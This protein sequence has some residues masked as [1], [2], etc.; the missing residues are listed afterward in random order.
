[1]PDRRSFLAAGSTSLALA[2]L[3]LPP[4]P[5]PQPASSSAARRP[6]P[7]RR[8]WRWRARSAAAPAVPAEPLPAAVLDKIGYEQLG[9]IKFSTDYALWATGRRPSRPPSSTSA[10]SSSAAC[11]S[12]SSKAGRRARDPLRRRPISTCRPTAR[13]TSCRRARAS[14]AS[15]SRRAA[16]RRQL[17][18]RKNDW[19][20]FLGASYFRSIGELYQYGLSARGIARQRRHRPTAPRSSRTSRDSDFEPPA[21][22]GDHGRGLCAARRPVRHRRLSLR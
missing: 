9:K 19:V 21:P 17:D 22:D 4:P 16:R 10:A 1:M 18:W 14:P 7:S 5:W 6:F 13:R 15:A 11:A 2:A 8:W 12:T 3:G 20:A